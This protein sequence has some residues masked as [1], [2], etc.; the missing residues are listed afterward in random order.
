MSEKVLSNQIVDTCLHVKKDENV[1]IHSWDHTLD[2]ASELDFACKQRGA[3]AI[4]T[5]ETEQHWLR[6]LRE[7]PKS[8]LEVLPVSQAA[9]LEKIDAF[10][11]MLGPRSPVDWSQI[12]P[13]KQE[14]ADV[15]YSGP[16]KYAKRWR[17]LARQHHLRMLGI[18]YCLVTAER[19]SSL[20]LDLKQWRS[21]MLAGC[22][23]DQKEISKRARK[24]ADLLQIGK[25]VTLVTPQ[26][27]D[28][29]FRLS[30]RVPNLGDS[31][32]SDDD[33]AKGI[34]KF[35]PSGFV[36]VAP[37]EDSAEGAIVYDFP[38]PVR[39][40]KKIEDLSLT[41][42]NGRVVD[43]SASSG[44]EAFQRYIESGSDDVDRFG[45][46]GVGL[47]PGLRHGF[48]QD[49]KVLGGVTVGIG[50]NEDKG[51]RNRTAGNNHWWASMTQATLRVDNK[52]VLQE[53]RYIFS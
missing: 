38:I 10:V 26:G 32:V 44:L 1:W 8:L 34:V 9:A 23:A 21:V 17:N 19:A 50:G 24:L 39:G 42:K 22:L 35:V 27:T 46:L 6:S 30:G 16:G 33:A 45:F 43:Y 5:I 13:E 11:F 37:D 18:E 12:P 28:L 40:A 14:L 2:L 25:E 7:L 41:F 15:W 20:G 53:G 29:N 51:G 48:T 3:H 52:H 47:N 49:D 36:E 31:V 4:T